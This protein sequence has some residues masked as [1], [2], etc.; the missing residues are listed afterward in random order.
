MK[1]LSVKQ[2]WAWLLCSGIKPIENR[3]RR[4]NFRGR[5]LIHASA[6]TELKN[7]LNVLSQDQWDLVKTFTFENVTLKHDVLS[8]IIGSVEIV[9]CVMNNPNF[10][11]EKGVWNWVVRNP[12]LFDTPI[13]G[14]KGKLSLW[15]YKLPEEYKQEIARKLKS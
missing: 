5:I 3:T 13:L 10:W 9:D 14:V 7:S 6:T 4:T 12:I 8:A 11:A 1:T 2:P 15:E